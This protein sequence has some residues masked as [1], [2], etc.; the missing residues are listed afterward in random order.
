MQQ[1]GVVAPL[2]QEAWF[3]L[4]VRS[5]QLRQKQIQPVLDFG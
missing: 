4:P 1:L 5:N 2:M 3:R